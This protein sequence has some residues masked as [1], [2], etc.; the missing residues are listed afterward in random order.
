[1]SRAQ[2]IVYLPNLASLVAREKADR[3]ITARQI[4]EE[5]GIDESQLMNLCAQRKGAS[6]GV[7]LRLA[8]HY[9]T[10]VEFL[11]GRVKTSA[12]LLATVE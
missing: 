2:E 10:S 12:K 5:L 9:K 3:G 8:A 6:L 1:M 4:S 7:A 11:A